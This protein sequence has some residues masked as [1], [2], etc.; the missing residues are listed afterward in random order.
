MISG[1]APAGVEERLAPMRTRLLDH[2]AGRVRPGLDDKVLADWNG[3]MI[4]ALVRAAPLLDRRGWIGLA[5][6]AYQFISESMTRDGRL[7]HSWRGGSLIYPG[8]A[9]DHAAMMRAALALYEV[10]GE[11]AYLRDAQNWRDVLL[12][13]YRIV[14][15]GVLAMTAQGGDPLVV[16]PQPAQDEAVPN[17]NGVFAEA[18]VR[19]AQITGAQADHRLAEETLQRLVGIARSSPLA[20][21]SILNALDLHLRGLS[22]VITGRD[23]KALHEAALRLL[24]LD[25]SRRA[26][27][28]GQMLDADHPAHALASAHE[29]PQALVC[30]GTHCSLP[31]QDPEAL[32]RRVQEMLRA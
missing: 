9:L 4:S 24:Y 29:G 27:R 21:T 31:V 1:E 20:H 8:F 28:E 3:L 10:T 30:A 7:G 18:L 13:D 5:Q 32:T 16:R 6:R 12:R 25:G 19:V 26:I 11:D 14:E 15:S 2:R 22:I 17:A 23:S